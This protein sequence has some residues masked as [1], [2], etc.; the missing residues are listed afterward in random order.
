MHQQERDRLISEYVEV[1]RRIALKVARR[2]PDSMRDD[3]VSAGMVGLTEAAHRFDDT[4]AEAF[5]PFAEPRIRGAVLDELRRGDMLPRRIRQQARLAASKIRELEATG[6]NVTDD[7]IAHALSVTVD[8]Y[9]DNLS[10]LMCIQ[11]VSL[12][13]GAAIVPDAHPLPSEVVARRELLRKVRTA[14]DKLEER[15][16]VLLGLHYLEEMTLADIA[17]T[18]QLTKSRVWQLLA[19]AVERLRKQLGTT[20]TELSA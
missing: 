6:E 13:D 11:S 9:R 17:V 19:R 16:L 14:L 18:M 7:K 3:L 10:S 8:D 1:A 15:D 2:C 5:L 20:V 12:D 4:R